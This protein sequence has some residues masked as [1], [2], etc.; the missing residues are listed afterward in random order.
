MC[1]DSFYFPVRLD[2]AH[3]S[4]IGRAISDKISVPA[5]RQG[6]GLS[7]AKVQCV[8]L[9]REALIVLQATVAHCVVLK[10]KK[11][12]QLKMSTPSVEGNS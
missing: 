4:F 6:S 9:Q 2:K 1:S 12:T 11:A 8:N 3:T 5:V 7:Y 10:I